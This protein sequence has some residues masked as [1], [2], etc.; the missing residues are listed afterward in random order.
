MSRE[1]YMDTG[2]R[3]EYGFQLC[4]RCG[5]WVTKC[6]YGFK[7]HIKACLKRTVVVK[8]KR[9]PPV[10]NEGKAQAKGGAE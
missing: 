1:R 9:Y 7:S 8:G 6:G 2:Q 4:P 5:K 3:N 10:K